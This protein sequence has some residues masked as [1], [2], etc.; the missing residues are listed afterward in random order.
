MVSLDEAAQIARGLP[1]TTEGERYGHR[2][3]F[4][5]DKGFA[6]ERPF[7]KADIKRYGTVN[8]PAGPIFAVAVADL[9]EKEAL[10]AKE[11]RGIFTIPHFNGYAAVLIELDRVNKAILTDVIVDAW[12]AV[13]PT[14]LADAYL[15]KEPTPRRH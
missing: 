14:A 10:P 11:H 7:S 2:T 13:A 9:G 4:V 15:A 6:W 12:L 1:E 8:P 3:W 5:R